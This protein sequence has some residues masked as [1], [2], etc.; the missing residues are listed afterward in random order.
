MGVV[1]ILQKDS[2]VNERTDNRISFRQSISQYVYLLTFKNSIFI[3][4]YWKIINYNVLLV[5]AVQ[6]R[7]SA[8][9]FY[10]Y[11]P[12][13][14]SLH[15]SSRHSLVIAEHWAKSPVLYSTYPPTRS[16]LHMVVCIYPVQLSQFP[17]RPCPSMFKMIGFTQNRIYTFEEH[18]V[19]GK[20]TSVIYNHSG[21]VRTTMS[22]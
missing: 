7:E 5:S 17:P 2:S 4:F 22:S 21:Q 10:T 6:Q 19:Q 15:P 11:L 9:H 8:T 3:Y 12:S 13:W 16:I 1:C 20:G 18:S 14:A